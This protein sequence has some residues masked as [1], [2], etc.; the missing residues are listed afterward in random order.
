MRFGLSEE[1]Q[2]LRD[3]VRR[4]LADQAQLDRVRLVAD[5][6][7]QEASS[8]LDGLLNLG[9]AGL[10][11]PESQGGLGLGAFEAAVVAEALGGAV[12]PVPFIGSY[13][14]APLALNRA[15][16][17]AQQEAW[18]P[19]IAAGDARLGVALTEFSGARDGTAL[20]YAGGCLNGTALFALDA[21]AV[22][23]WL[24]AD[25]AGQMYLVESSAVQQRLLVSIDRTRRLAELSLDQAPAEPLPGD[26][27]DTEAVLDL[28]RVLLAAD[29]IGAAQAMLD[30]AVAY[31]GER[32][33]FGRLI[34]SFQAVKHLCAEMVAELEP[35]RALV[36]YAAYAQDALPAES[37]LL[38]CHAKA[39]TGEIGRFIAKTA[40]EVHGGMGFTD[41][42]GLH[43]WFKRLG[44]NRLLLGGPEQLRSEAAQ[45]QGWL[46]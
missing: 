28:G 34:G 26:R 39:H 41:M 35:A 17:P 44:A 21:G 43:Y 2:L 45:V 22:D 4:Y 11:V 38:A 29:S 33:Q 32:Q 14:M 30:K 31:A 23:A 8:I 6:D 10:L 18:L 19:R 9:L 16:S 40:T 5:G 3:S 37:R 36:W 7:E 24:L 42:L 1:Q 13:A 46:S 20:R 12:A 25:S 27:A 15:G